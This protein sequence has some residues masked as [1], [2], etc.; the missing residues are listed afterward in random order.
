[1]KTIDFLP[2]I[3]R[4]RIALRQA[5][6]WWGIVVL[7]FGV[8]I[9]STAAAQHL[10]KK[11]VQK[12]FD[13]LA[14]QYAE[15]QLQVQRLGKVQTDNR[16]AGHW[17]GLVTYLEQPWPR[18]QLI[19]EVVRPLPA[20]VRLTELIV[21]EE[22]A[23]RPV[24]EEAGPRRRSRAAEPPAQKLAPPLADLEALRKAH[25]YKRPVIEITGTIGDVAL[26]HE[27]VGEVGRSPL[28]AR[29]LIKSHASPATAALD[30]P[31]TF[32]VRVVFRPSHG[33]PDAETGVADGD[34]ARGQVAQGGSGS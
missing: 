22:E 23:A 20:A 12:Q 31:T 7:I 26:L 10:L 17:A 32:T 1:M 3:Y 16:T 11:S 18:S 6:V 5:R 4:E 8:A 14:P 27:Y 34:G 30:Q 21:A 9:V 25:D 19:A 28:V 33:Q 24:T 2:E 29:A 13:D 15:A